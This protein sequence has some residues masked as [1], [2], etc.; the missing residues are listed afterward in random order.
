[1]ILA[2]ELLGVRPAGLIRAGKRLVVLSGLLADE[3]KIQKARVREKNLKY[4]AKIAADAAKREARL[5]YMREWS[6]ANREK[7][8]AYRA[9]WIAQNREW[10]RKYQREWAQRKRA[11][12]AGVE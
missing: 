9:K 3:V 4:R 6:K 7:R 2:A 11:Q 1:M 8:K 5:A 12:K 10:N